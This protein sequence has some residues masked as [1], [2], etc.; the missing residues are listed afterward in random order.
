M[1]N[2]PRGRPTGKSSTG[3]NGKPGQSKPR[4]QSSK[5]STES[6]EKSNQEWMLI[7]FRT[8]SK[9]FILDLTPSINAH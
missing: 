3:G 8:M 2:S 4:S 1:N 6:L 9:H 5:R 7:G